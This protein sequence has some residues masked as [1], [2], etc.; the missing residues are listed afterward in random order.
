MKTSTKTVRLIAGY[1]G[2]VFVYDTGDIVWESSPKK[3]LA[4]ADKAAKKAQLRAVKRSF[5]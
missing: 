1:V 5:A 4:K 3:T 2:Q